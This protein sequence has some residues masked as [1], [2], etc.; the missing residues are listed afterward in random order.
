MATQS[1]NIPAVPT[2][3]PYTAFPFN[4]DAIDQD[5]LRQWCQFQPRYAK[6]PLRRNSLR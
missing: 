1:S 4:I 3:N 5:W 2:L 6:I